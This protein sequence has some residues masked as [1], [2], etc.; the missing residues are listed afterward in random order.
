MA[1]LSTG[2]TLNILMLACIN[3]KN[4]SVPSILFFI[5]FK[6]NSFWSSNSNAAY[7][8]SVVRIQH[9]KCSELSDTFLIFKEKNYS[10]IMQRYSNST[11]TFCNYLSF[12]V[13]CKTIDYESFYFC[14]NDRASFKISSNVI[15]GFS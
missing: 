13:W 2:S 3:S 1:N 6:L 9:L 7:E 11:S 10:F 4:K 12:T 5:F 14:C 8:Y 15:L